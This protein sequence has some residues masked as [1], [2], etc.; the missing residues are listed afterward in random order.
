VAKS[1]N[2]YPTYFRA[3]IFGRDIGT[4]AYNLQLSQRR[5]EA[6]RGFLVETLVLWSGRTQ[7]KHAP[8]WLKC[9]FGKDYGSVMWSLFDSRAR[10]KG[11]PGYANSIRP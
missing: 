1:F 11:G 6:V 4:Q 3:D 10:P 7:I 8:V 9:S 5:A 2:R